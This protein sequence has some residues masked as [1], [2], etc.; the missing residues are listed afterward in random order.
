MTT[1]QSVSG[2]RRTIW[3]LCTLLVLATQMPAWGDVLL[4]SGGPF[5]YPAPHPPYNA[6]QLTL[7]FTIG[8]GTPATTLGDG[9]WHSGPGP[10]DLSQDPDFPAFVDMATNAQFDWVTVC[11]TD[12]DGFQWTYQYGEGLA[13]GLVGGSYDLFPCDIT[14]IDLVVLGLQSG[15]VNGDPYAVIGVRTDV[16]GIPEPTTGI[17]I[18][19]LSGAYIGRRQRLL[20]A[21]HA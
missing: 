10:Y 20:S 4:A 6:G 14:R 1:S 17:S 18:A 5:D 7:E 15:V 21:G 13:F 16:F 11:V 2:I 3:L 8:Y 12:T 9:L 19:L